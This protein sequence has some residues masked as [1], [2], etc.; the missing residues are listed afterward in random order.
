MNFD[1]ITTLKKSISRSIWRRRLWKISQPSH[2]SQNATLFEVTPSTTNRRIAF[3]EGIRF[4]RTDRKPGMNT[5]LATVELSTFLQQE[6]ASRG[7]REGQIKRHRGPNP[8][9][10]CGLEMPGHPQQ[11]LHMPEIRTLKRRRTHWVTAWVFY[12]SISADLRRR[13]SA[14]F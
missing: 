9:E 8:Q 5:F 3:S 1:F 11:G 13:L 2:S 12:P 4:E 14:K 7:Q 10:T 6:W